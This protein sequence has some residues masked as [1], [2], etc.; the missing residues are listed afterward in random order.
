VVRIKSDDP[1]AYY[2]LGLAYNSVSRSEEAIESLKEAVR[3]KQDYA[4]AQYGLGIVYGGLGRWEEAKKALKDAI[5]IKPGYAEAHAMLGTAC[6]ATGDK[7][8]ALEEY[9][10]LKTLDVKSADRLFNLINR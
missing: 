9:K 3:I 1:E 2:S 5:K 7:D 8:S 10:I 6:L 4:E